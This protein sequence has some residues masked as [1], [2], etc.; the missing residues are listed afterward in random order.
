MLNPLHSVIIIRT[1]DKIKQAI[2]WKP[3]TRRATWKRK[4]RKDTTY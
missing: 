1:D 2:G 3:L 4:K